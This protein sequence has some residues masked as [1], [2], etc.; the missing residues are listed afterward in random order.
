MGIRSSGKG[1]L[2]LFELTVKRRQDDREL[3]AQWKEKGRQ[4]NDGNCKEK[5]FEKTLKS[6]SQVQPD[7]DL[8]G[9][10]TPPN[11]RDLQET[12]C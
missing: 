12:T 10:R 7:G 8:E 6:S 2:D 1:P 9:Q 11:I 3:K 4:G 5:I